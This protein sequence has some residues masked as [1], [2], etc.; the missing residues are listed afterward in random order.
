MNTSPTDERLA[1][2][3]PTYRWAMPAWWLPFSTALL[4][5]MVVCGAWG[6]PRM[7]EKNGWPA[8]L[9]MAAWFGAFLWN[10]YWW[11]FRVAYKLELDGDTLRWQA[12]LARGELSVHSITGVTPFLNT[13]EQI[14]T[15]RAVGHRSI[16]VFA[17]GDLSSFLARLNVIN[18]A[19]PDRVGG[20]SGFFDR[21]GSRKRPQ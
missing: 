13:Q 3:G 21:A 16:P 2:S 14:P 7:I 18:T 17:R 1:D 12:P 8:A 20:F 5:F 19:V 15:I 6:A 10:V 11:Y 9:F 4:L